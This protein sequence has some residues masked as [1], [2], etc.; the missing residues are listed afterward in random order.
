MDLFVYGS[1]L[2]VRIRVSVLSTKDL[3]PIPGPLLRMILA[4][5][6]KQIHKNLPS[7]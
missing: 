2:P 4:G 5:F 6:I 3:N 1:V 7:L